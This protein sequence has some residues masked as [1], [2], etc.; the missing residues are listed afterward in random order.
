LYPT[1]AGGMAN[2]V[3]PLGSSES[4][5]IYTRSDPTL[6]STSISVDTKPPATQLYS[7]TLT[8]D[9]HQPPGSPNS[10]VTLYGP[11]S[12]ASY[13]SK[14]SIPGD[15]SA[16]YWTTSANGSPTPIDY[17]GSG[18]GGTALQNSV[19]ADGATTSSPLQ[20]TAFTTFG[21]NGGAGPSTSWNM[22]FDDSY[23][24]SEYNLLMICS[25]LV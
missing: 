3:V 16:Q 19:V 24:A 1:S 10:Q 18:Y 11:G 22:S 12:T 21:N 14:F 9:Q 23:D 15:P 7:Q 8:Y 20:Q 5:L 2:K 13:I 6:T 25:S 17:V 4:P